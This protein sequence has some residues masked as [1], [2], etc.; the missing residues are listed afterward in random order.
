MRR[1]W[2][3]DLRTAFFLVESFRVRVGNTLAFYI[4][5]FKISVYALLLTVDALSI[6]ICAVFENL[7]RP[8]PQ[9]KKI[10]DLSFTRVLLA[11]VCEPAVTL[12]HLQY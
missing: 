1:V 4:L 12:C 6:K 5:H 8:R 9:L 3:E 7:G 2:V 11:R 10:S